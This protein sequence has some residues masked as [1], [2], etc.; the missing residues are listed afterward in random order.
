MLYVLYKKNHNLSSGIGSFP[1]LPF[2]PDQAQKESSQRRQCEDRDSQQK[3]SK[4]FFGRK[5]YG[6]LRKQNKD[7]KQMHRNSPFYESKTTVYV[8][9]NL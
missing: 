9:R 3:R 1:L 5:F 8:L 4:H 6:V 2:S 7:R